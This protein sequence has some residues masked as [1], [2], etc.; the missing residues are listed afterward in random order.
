MAK[1]GEGDK[2][3]I[4]E[5]R[6]DGTNVHNWHWSEKDCLEWSRKRFQSLLSDLVLV[7]SDDLHIKTTSVDKV[8]GDAYVNIRKGKI[9]PG[10]DLS[11]SVS[12]SGRVGGDSEAVSGTILFPYIADENAD[13]DPEIRLSVASDSPNAE[14]LRQALFAKGKPVLLE[15]VREFVKHINAGGPAKDELGAK[16]STDSNKSKVRQV[17]AKDGS[18]EKTTAAASTVTVKAEKQ[19]EGF[20]TIRLTERFHC[21]PQ[22][23]YEILMDE[24]RWKGF[25]GSNAKISKEVGGSFSLFDGA[26]TGVFEQLQPPKLIVQKWRFANWADGIFSQVTRNTFLIFAFI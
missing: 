2:R 5:E 7:D 21:R 13:Q 1:Y 11:V 24:N 4:V 22:D 19:P 26:V 8:E 10:Y 14:V 17:V 25:T 20:K 23:L 9:I 16:Q 15:K 12:W 18:K 6:A 3:W